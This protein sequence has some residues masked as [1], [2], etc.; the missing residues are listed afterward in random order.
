MSDV[1]DRSDGG[2][3][4]RRQQA[5]E[6]IMRGETPFAVAQACGLSLTALNRLTARFRSGGWPAVT[7]LGNGPLPGKQR[8][9]TPQQE[10]ELIASIASHA[11]HELGLAGTLW[12]NATVLELV[13]RTTG[14]RLTRSTMNGY[15]RRWGFVRSRSTRH[16]LSGDPQILRHW[17]R[18]TYPLVLAEARTSM[19]EV[20]WLSAWPSAHHT[21]GHVL[22]VS[23]SRGHTRWAVQ[24][25]PL[26]G[27]SIARFIEGLAHGQEGGLT[28]ILP[29]RLH[30]LV[31]PLLDPA[32]GPRVRVHPLPR[33]GP[34]M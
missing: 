12:D 2:L 11:P 14:Q 5:I 34:I 3:E 24:A 17:R 10:Q 21:E 15:L 8:R 22:L 13:V 32:I 31:G 4:R 9:L 25:G 26:D 19:N 16:A 20:H 23:T 18:S 30:G 27:G 7:A 28:I 29:H 33:L 6:L 1:L